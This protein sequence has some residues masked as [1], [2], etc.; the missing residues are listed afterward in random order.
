MKVKSV[1]A[2]ITL[3]LIGEFTFLLPFV[4]FRIFR[5]TFLTVFQINNFQL[6]S[7]FSVYGI[8]AMISYFFGGPIADRFSPRQLL[9][10]A[11]IFTSLGGLVLI[12]IPSMELLPVLYGFWGMTTILL[13]W[14]AYIKAQREYGGK[15]AQGKS[16]GAVDAGRGLIAAIIASSSVFLLDAFLPVSAE[17]ASYD[18]LK[19]AVQVIIG[20]FTFITAFGSILIWVFLKDERF[21]KD[22]MNRL[23]I[24]GILDALKRRSVWLQALIVLCAYVGYKVTDDFSLFAKDTF[25]Y[26][27][28]DAAHMA[29]ITFWMRPIAAIAAG[30]LGDRMLHSKIIAW[31]FGIIILGSVTVS[32]GVLSAD[33]W[34]IIVLT[35]ASTSAAI[36][37]LRG[38]YYALF[39]EARLPVLIT[40]S[41]AGV[42]S[43]IGYTPDIFM[44]PLM[45]VILDNN[46]G[47]PGHQ[48]LFGVL[49]G[50]SL[51]GLVTAVIFKKSTFS[52]PLSE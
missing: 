6:G 25:G 52:N 13:F 5:P 39:Q 45:G 42:V 10:V 43:V 36:Y 49:A 23:S 8:V 11:M 22:N 17:L 2:L 50:F 20:I 48:L 21:E 24:K 32:S 34:L 7:A 40:G 4:V 27:D 28:V 33:W 47:A 44:G 38:V 15:Y 18:Q 26:N 14:P 37:G 30:Y 16:Y 1:W 19:Y 35:I 51:L 41:A 12:S 3:M 31:C 46:P 29:T 9:P